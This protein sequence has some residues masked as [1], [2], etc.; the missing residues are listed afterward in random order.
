MSQVELVRTATA[1][2]V[3]LDGAL[4]TAI[5]DQGSTHQLDAM[6]LLHGVGSN[7]YG[8]MLMESL[9]GALVQVGI[10]ALRVNTRGHDT[11]STARCGDGVKR[12]GAA[13]EIVADACL[14]INA[15][16]DYLVTRGHRTIGVLGHSLGAVKVCYA[17]AH[18]PHPQ[19][20]CVIPVSPPRLS[21]AAFRESADSGR[22]LHSLGEAESLVAAGRP[23][24]LFLSRFPFPTLMSAACYV[25]K[26]GP[27]ERYNVLNFVDSID[28]PALYVFGQAEV[29]QGGIA[30]AGMPEAIRPS[31]DAG[32]DLQVVAGAD[33]FYS[34][35]APA[36]IE[37]V[38][39]WL[40]LRFSA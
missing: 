8:S 9:A 33:H 32:R 7:F 36:L 38:L 12:V 16:V 28:C 3:R 23:D 6:I 5:V 39:S 25:D 17:L 4:Q 37:I 14:D 15:W 2:Q 26:Y 30:F 13:Y 31:A 18:Q 35:Q 24:D 40:T 22:F 29:E 27:A 1:D 11:V 34:G 21:C 19:V 10:A 20:A